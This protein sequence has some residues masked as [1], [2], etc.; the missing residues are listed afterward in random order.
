MPTGPMPVRQI[1]EVDRQIVANFR[2]R[3][4]EAVGRHPVDRVEA[5]IADL[6]LHHIL[7]NADAAVG[8]VELTEALHQL[9]SDEWFPGICLEF[10]LAR[11]ILDLGLVGYAVLACRDMGSALD[12]LYRYHGLTSDAY[13]VQLSAS[14]DLASIRIRIR[15]A[16][17]EY[18][19]VIGEEFATGL[20][21][22]LAEVLSPGIDMSRIRIDLD[23]PA[24]SYAAR[25]G[26]LLP[27]E[28]R[29]AQDHASVSF[30]AAWQQMAIQSADATIEQV[31]RAQCDALLEGRGTGREVVD[32][33]WR[34]LLSVPSNRPPSLAKVAEEMM[35][36][37]R[38]LERRLLEA[39]SS[40]RSIQSAVR[41]SLAAQY[42]TLGSVS[43]EEIA[44][45][46]G[47]SQPSAFYRAF[48]DWFGMT[49][50]QFRAVGSS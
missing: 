31:C 45:L 11:R 7:F 12:I 14:D 5:A 18:R 25:Y 34:L 4:E 37:P 36:S 19:T 21:V 10:G 29:F 9:N 16:F 38:T 27:C 20:W 8:D 42:V 50:T 17:A 1:E 44:Y 39:G 33:V 2:A 13:Q 22:F 49:P 40:F 28:I 23:Y 32:D 48:K 47:Y 15:P 3:L 26:E 24:P 46:L 6:G 41:K 30:P 35:M 43:G